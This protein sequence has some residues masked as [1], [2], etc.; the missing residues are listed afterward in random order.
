MVIHSSAVLDTFGTFVSG[1]EGRDVSNATM[2]VGA[3]RT[4]ADLATIHSKGFRVEIDD[5]KLA[6]EMYTHITQH[7]KDAIEYQTNGMFGR[8]PPIEDLQT[9]DKFAAY[10]FPRVRHHFVAGTDDSSRLMSHL[11]SRLRKSRTK[12][13]TAPEAHTSLTTKIDTRQFRGTRNWK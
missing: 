6:F 3:I 12:A 5:D 10:I 2:L 8:M 7:I 1:D 9:L 13:K 11:G 4:V